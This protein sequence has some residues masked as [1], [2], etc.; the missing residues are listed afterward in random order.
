MMDTSIPGSPLPRA[1]N[2]TLVSRYHHCDRRGYPAGLRF[3]P[4]HPGR[5]P[6]HAY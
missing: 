5:L 1:S 3:P 2:M 4:A 6:G